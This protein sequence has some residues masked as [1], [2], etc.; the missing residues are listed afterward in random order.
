ML[1]KLFRK[2]RLAWFQMTREKTRLAVALAGIAFADILMFI[3]LG[4]KDALYNT[5]IRPHYALQGDL[6]LINPK[7]ETLVLEKSFSRTRLYQAAGFEG[8]ESVSPLYISRGYWRNPITK[9]DRTI[10]IFGIDPANSAFKLPEV[11]QH[12]D[13]L[14]MLNQVLFDRG[15]RL[16]FGPITDLFHQSGSAETELNNVFIRV[17]G[18]FTVGASFAADGNIITS[19]S[20]F[21]RLFPSRQP[22]QIEVGLIRLKPDA[23]SERV[24]ANLEGSLPT[25][26]KVLTVEGFAAGEKKYWENATPIGFVFGLGSLVGFIVGTVIVYQVLYTDVSDH[27]PEYATLKAMGYGDHY[28]VS[29][30]IQESLILAI[31]GF[32]PGVAL[33][34]GVYHI[35]RDATRL[36]VDMTANRAI[37][38][39]VL[40]TVMCT[41]SGAIAMRKLQT[42]DPAD[43]F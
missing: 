18:L 7:F 3:Q 30:L 27:L 6:F 38:V 9:I 32:I 37:T 21:L 26:V 11:N 42:A 36:P 12:L 8:V 24:K 4:F 35:A 23:D 41:A 39:L 40:T 15:S 22:D 28:L 13:E 5:S 17:A 10:L 2:T 43:I 34:L 25:D 16:E 14:K 31:L 20:T 29:V 1:R 33:S 19:D